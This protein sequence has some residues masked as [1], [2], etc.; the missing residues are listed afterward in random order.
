MGVQHRLHVGATL[1]DCAVDEALEVERPLLGPGRRPVEMEFDDVVDADDAGAARAGQQIPGRIARVADAHVPIGVEHPLHREDA[2]GDDDVAPGALDRVHDGFLRG[3]RSVGVHE[4]RGRVGKLT[5]C[6]RPVADPMLS[7]DF[8]AV[9]AQGSTSIFITFRRSTP[10]A[11]CGRPRPGHRPRY[12]EWTLELALDLMDRS[13]IQVALS[14]AGAARCRIGTQFSAGSWRG[15]ARLRGG[16]IARWPKRFGA[17]TVPMEHRGAIREIAH[18]LDDLR[19]GG[20]PVCKLRHFSAMCGFDP[21]LEALNERSAVVF[22][23]PGLHPSSATLAPWPGFMMEY[24][25]IRRAPSST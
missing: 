22:V 1:V 7:G 8:D 4:P 25:S 3:G 2:V 12:P 5:V 9:V 20:L 16:L 10:M 15:A 24:S 23:H 17:A 18:C 14:R 13:D 19:F 6:H 11:P 21:V